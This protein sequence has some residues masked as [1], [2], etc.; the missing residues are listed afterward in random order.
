MRRNRITITVYK[1][2]P[3]WLAYLYTGC[4][5]MYFLFQVPSQL[6]WVDLAYYTDPIAGFC[7]KVAQF[8]APA[9]ALLLWFLLAAVIAVVVVGL[10]QSIYRAIR[11]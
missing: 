11:G 1:D 10:A 9:L 2:V 8:F 7:Y 3:L 6:G 4:S 5:N